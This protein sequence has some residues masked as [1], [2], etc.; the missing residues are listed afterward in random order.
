MEYFGRVI[1]LLALRRKI[2][3]WVWKFTVGGRILLKNWHRVVWASSFNFDF[4]SR[5]K[6]SV[7]LWRVDKLICFIVAL[8]W[9][10]CKILQKNCKG[11]RSGFQEF[12]FERMLDRRSWGRNFFWK[13]NGRVFLRGEQKPFRSKG[14][15]VVEN[16]SHCVDRLTRG[17]EKITPRLIRDQ[18]L[19]KTKRKFLAF[20]WF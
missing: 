2:L 11:T 19:I 18:F 3:E 13:H 16:S 12:E 15:S 5:K 20:L 10:H 8:F 7:G 6:N 1:A 4:F 14:G 17:W 9:L